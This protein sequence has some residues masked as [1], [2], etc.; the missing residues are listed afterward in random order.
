MTAPLGMTPPKV[1]QAVTEMQVQPGQGGPGGP[2]AQALSGRLPTTTPTTPGAKVAAIQPGQNDLRG[3]QITPGAGPRLQSMTGQTDQARSAYAS[4]PGYTPYAAVPTAGSPYTAQANDL[5][6][7]A[8]G[9]LPSSGYQPI[10]AGTNGQAS[11][12]LQRAIGSAGE[13]GGAGFGGDTQAARAG[14]MSALNTLNTAP[15]RGELA[16]QQF[17]L[18]QEQSQPGFEQD[19]RRVGQRASALGR[20][21]AGMTTSDLGTVAQRRAESLDQNARGLA[22]DAAAR[23]MEDRL[24]RVSANQGVAGTFGGLDLGAS[25]LDAE[26]ARSRAGILSGLSDQSYGQDMGLRNEARGEQ[27]RGLQYGVTQGDFLGRLSDQSFNRG[28]SLRNEDRDERDTQR[29]F[30]EGDLSRVRTQLGDF[31]GL[32]DNQRS[33]EASDRNELRGERGYQDDLAQVGIDRAVQQRGFEEDLQNSATSRDR[34]YTNDLFD[35]GYSTDPTGMIQGGADRMAGQAQ[36]EW[37]GAGDALGEYMAGRVSPGMS[38]RTADQ[39]IG[40][41]VPNVVAAQPGAAK[42]IRPMQPWT[43]PVLQGG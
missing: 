42:P 34:N 9:S 25:G 11:S 40:S 26:S 16:A 31:A 3:T 14:T 13:I 8:A 36:N 23:E 5:S 39:V 18:M 24:A 22:T 12:L 37:A 6:T 28:S 21:G 30:E 1:R 35:M 2:I 10:S 20:V 41:S 33:W 4:A 7:R 17:A 19:L 43:Q 27:D 15:N 29:R 32:E 38:R